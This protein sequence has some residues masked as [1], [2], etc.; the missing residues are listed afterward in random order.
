MTCRYDI[1]TARI[2]EFRAL[3][4]ETRR[5]V[6]TVYVPDAALLAHAYPEWAGLGGTANLM[7]YGE[8][9]QSVSEPASLYFP[10]GVI[11]NRGSSA[12]LNIADIQEHVNTAGTTGML[13]VSHRLGS[14]H[15]STRP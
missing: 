9:P 7:A 12:A 14:P 5:F 4:Q 8:F 10:Q 6:E 1:N 15:P 3:L 11:L 13:H 2:N